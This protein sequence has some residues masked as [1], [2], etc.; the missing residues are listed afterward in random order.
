MLVFCIWYQSLQKQIKCC[1]F[2]LLG[3]LSLLWPVLFIVLSLKK[4]HFI[5]HSLTLI[6]IV[7]AISLQDLLTFLSLCIKTMIII[8]YIEV[9]II[10]LSLVDQKPR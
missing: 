1:D 5:V 6:S 9:L 4:F 2:S 8:P 7:S 3:P 10:F